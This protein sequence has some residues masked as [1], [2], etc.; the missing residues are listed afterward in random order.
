MVFFCFTFVN[1]KKN[2]WN[3]EKKSYWEFSLPINSLQHHVDKQC[4]QRLLIT[5][6]NGISCQNDPFIHKVMLTMFV[7]SPLYESLSF[8]IKMD[9]QSNT[10]KSNV[11]PFPVMFV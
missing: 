6:I 5:L 4:T 2:F 9:D 8:Y 11:Y 7:Y 3:L 10:L 1:E